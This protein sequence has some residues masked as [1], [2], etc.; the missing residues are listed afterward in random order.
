MV[1]AELPELLHTAAVEVGMDIADVERNMPVAA[2][3]EDFVFD[4]AVSE[5]RTLNT[6][7]LEGTRLDTAVV[8][9]VLGKVEFDDVAGKQMT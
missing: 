4:I 1:L 3:V 7:L 2:V 5:G 8:E 9:D 6:V